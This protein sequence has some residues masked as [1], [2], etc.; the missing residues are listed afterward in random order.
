MKTFENFQYD[1]KLGVVCCYFNPCN[2]RSKFLNYIT[3]I[4]NIKQHGIRVL[5]VE[6]YSV[7]SKYRI[8][9]LN[10][11]TISIK[12][13]QTY[14]M[15]ECLLN[16]GIKKLLELGYENIAWV[17]ADIIFKSLTWPNS[18]L[19]SLKKYQVVQI[20]ENCYEESMNTSVSVYKPSMM[21]LVKKIKTPMKNILM[22]R[23]E[24]GYG[25]AYRSD[26]LQKC[27]LYD[28][29]IVGAGDFANLVGCF[30]SDKHQNLLRK[31][32]FFVNTTE[33]FFS[34]YC[35]WATEM[36]HAVDSN[37]GVSREDI[38]IL[39]HGSR[40]KRCYRSRESIIKYY[41]Y[42]PTCDLTKLSNG[43][44]EITKKQQA[45]LKSIEK[46]FMARNEDENIA[47]ESPTRLKYLQRTESMEKINFYDK[48][49]KQ[50]RVASPTHYLSV[51]NQIFL[52]DYVEGDKVI[53]NY[54]EHLELMDKNKPIPRHERKKNRSSY[55]LLIVASRHTQN[56]FI[57]NCKIP[58]LIFSKTGTAKLGEFQ[59]SSYTDSISHTYLSYLINDYEELPHTL[60]FVNDITYVKAMQHW[61][62]SLSKIKT[63]TPFL[64]EKKRIL[65]DDMGHI[66]FRHQWQ[67]HT[68][69]K[70]N[71]DFKTWVKTYLP[72]HPIPTHTYEGSTFAVTREIIWKKPKSFYK[73]LISALQ[74]RYCEE[75]YYFEFC[76]ETIFS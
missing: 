31:D 63:Y 57:H 58:H 24:L 33:D 30:Y 8:D 47:P 49:A 43:L 72:S 37:V 41:S 21:S 19:Q 66:R 50:L 42:K 52:T 29:A 10:N 12:C 46:Q 18:I 23:G 38:I 68:M 75:E 22:R 60:I 15:K 61:M 64:T 28:K 27:L 7:N 34:D 54:I 1:K 26:V 35:K 16:I 69:K 67:T 11:D 14:W 40:L 39:N 36:N 3:F 70:S 32:R 56:P 62:E 5:T 2:Y 65:Y 73:S 51:R 9:K 4:Q 44:F 76:W 20:F 71:Y 6:S 55:P 48:S 25:Y 13:N 45:M 59:L 74:N 53:S 17:D